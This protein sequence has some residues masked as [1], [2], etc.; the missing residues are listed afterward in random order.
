[1]YVCEREK[2]VSRDRQTEKISREIK[3]CQLVGYITKELRTLADVVVVVSICLFAVVF[4]AKIDLK[5]VYV[6]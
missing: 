1:M 5:C 3:V 4:D 2:S 6:R